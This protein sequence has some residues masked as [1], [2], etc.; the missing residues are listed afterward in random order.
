MSLIKTY[1]ILQDA[2][3]TAFTDSELFRE[4]QQGAEGGINPPYPLPHRHT[5]TH[6]HREIRDNQKHSPILTR[7]SYNC[8]SIDSVNDNSTTQEFN[9]S[10]PIAKRELMNAVFRA[11]FYIC[12]F[13]SC[14]MFITALA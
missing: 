5:H 12:T 11:I 14:S 10:S 1:L 6:T 3:I 9:L 13:F 4:N 2:S 7:I 8:I